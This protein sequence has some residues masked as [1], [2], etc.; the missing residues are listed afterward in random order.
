MERPIHA[1]VIALCNV[2]EP[3]Q[4]NICAVLKSTQSEHTWKSFP[5]LKRSF[6]QKC[7]SSNPV[8]LFVMLFLK[9]QA[10]FEVTMP[11]SKPDV[12]P[13]VCH[14]PSPSLLVRALE[15][16]NPPPRVEQC[17]APATQEEHFPQF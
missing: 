10:V 8:F 16:A 4:A 1:V 17:V 11:L 13:F 12:A 2:T 15:V 6:S 14:P 5:A 7:Q 3:A 9:E